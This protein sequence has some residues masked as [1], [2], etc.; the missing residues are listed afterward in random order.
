MPYMS[1]SCDR[2]KRMCACSIRRACYCCTAAAVAVAYV[3][4]SKLMYAATAVEQ[5]CS[6]S[7]SSL[8]QARLLLTDADVC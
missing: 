3:S 7:V 4:M 1:L 6:S 2:H 5:C 8:H